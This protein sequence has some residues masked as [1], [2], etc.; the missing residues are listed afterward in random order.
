MIKAR[1]IGVDNELLQS[2][3]VYKIKTI[4]VMWNGKPRLRVAF[5]ERFR[6]W[7]HYGSL[8]E[9]LESK[10]YLIIPT[11]GAYEVLRARK[12]KEN[13]VIVYR[14]GGA[15]EHLSIMDKDFYLVNEFLRTREAVVSK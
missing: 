11:V 9:F 14:K 13:M 5:G 8:E 6:Y 4:S 15:K 12:P 7:V 10:G 2:G 3:K 1:Y